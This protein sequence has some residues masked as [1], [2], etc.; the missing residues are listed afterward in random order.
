MILILN[1]VFVDKLNNANKMEEAS[2]AFSCIVLIQKRKIPCYF[3]CSI[4]KIWG[5]FFLLISDL[6]PVISI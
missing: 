3:S 4:D 5:V 1:L 6:F 2:E